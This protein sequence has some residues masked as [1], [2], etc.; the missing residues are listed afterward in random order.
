MYVKLLGIIPANFSIIDHLQ[1]YLSCCRGGQGSPRAVAPK[2]KICHVVETV[3]VQWN[4]RL[5]QLFIDFR[6]PIV[7][8]GEVLYNIIEFSI[9]LKLIRLFKCLDETCRKVT[10]T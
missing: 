3:G 5:Q 6:R 4:S 7:R 1:L 8:L 2:K 9:L 10:C